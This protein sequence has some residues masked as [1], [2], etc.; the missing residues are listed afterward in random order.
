MRI[1]AR[2]SRKTLRLPSVTLLQMETRHHHLAKLSIDDSMK[3]IEFGDVLIMSDKFN[4][5]KAHGAKHVRV[6][7]WPAKIGYSRALWYEVPQHIKTSHVLITQWDS[8]VIHPEFWKP[9]FLN[10]D[11][12]GAPW[13]YHDGFNVG[14]SGFSLR[15][16]RLMDFLVEHEKEFPLDRDGEDMMLSRI[17]RPKLEERG[18]AWAPEDLAFEFAVETNCPR[19]MQAF[20]FHGL[21]HF[22]HVL[23]RI[24]LR[25][26]A[27]HILTNE[28]M[29]NVQYINGNSMSEELL[30]EAPWLRSDMKTLERRPQQVQVPRVTLT[31]E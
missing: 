10:Y 9:Q 5:L 27:K 12:I 21:Y 24:D 19:G 15:S 4:V 23:S 14:N 17:H 28:Y 18:F 13:H 1:L 6:D 3:A 31:Y 16:K 20:G 2:T 30:K 11:Y 29:C 8:W 26:R 7:D 25:V 22:P